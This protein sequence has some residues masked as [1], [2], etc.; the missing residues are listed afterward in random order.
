M[1]RSYL[2][3]LVCVLALAFASGTA[4][5]DECDDSGKLEGRYLDQCKSTLSRNCGTSRGAARERCAQRVVDQI[6]KSQESRRKMESERSAEESRW[7]SCKSKEYEQACAEIA[8]MAAICQNADSVPSLARDVDDEAARYVSA[9][10]T[11]DRLIGKVMSFESRFGQCRNAPSHHM[12]SCRFSYADRCQKAKDAFQ[13]AVAESISD[14]EREQLP[15]MTRAIDE[16]KRG[17]QAPTSSSNYDIDG[18][19]PKLAGLQRIAAAVPWL[20]EQARRLIQ[21]E[22]VVEGRTSEYRAALE[23][24]IGKVQ[25]PV[26]KAGSG[27]F[28]GILRA[29]LD[30]TKKPGSTMVETVKRFEAKGKTRVTREPLTRTTHEDQPGGMCVEQRRGDQVD[31]RIFQVTFRRSKVDG[32]G[33]GPWGFYSIGGGALMSCSNLR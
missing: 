22:K 30:S 5:A 8:P 1:A 7:D 13:A 4:N 32:S 23:S 12:P 17:G 6:V 20:R 3:V 21:I 27:S 29:H 19:A 14:L 16:L 9:L 2:A 33:W 24:L 15:A 10:Q 11:H 26:K 18:V 28:F 25:C 31:C